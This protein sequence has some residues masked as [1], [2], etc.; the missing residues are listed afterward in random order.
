MGIT[1]K[2]KLGDSQSTESLALTA[3]PENVLAK[4]TPFLP[5]G[6]STANYDEFLR[7][8]AAK[9][10]TFKPMGEKIGEYTLYSFPNA[11]FELYKCT[12]ETPRFKEYHRRLQL[13]LLF[14]IEAASYIEETDEAW[15]VILVYALF[16]VLLLQYKH[17]FN[18]QIALKIRKNVTVWKSRVC[19]CRICDPV[20]ILLP[21]GSNKNAH[22]A[23]LRYATLPR[24]GSWM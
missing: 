1:Y 8:A 24:E 3:P 18:D 2:A 6:F 22:F 5:E 21:S 11:V 9:D 14:F 20:S 16:S 17:V 15:E 13:F 10:D 7:L 12:F 23:V 19:N 4:L